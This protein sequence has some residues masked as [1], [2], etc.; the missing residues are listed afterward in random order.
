MNGVLRA[1]L[2]FIILYLVFR[3]VLNFGRKDKK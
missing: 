3:F 1:V 2:V